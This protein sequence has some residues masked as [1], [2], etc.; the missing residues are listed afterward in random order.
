MRP[1]KE[2]KWRIL[3]IICT[4]V[5]SCFWALRQHFHTIGILAGRH[6][7]QSFEPPGEVVDRLKTKALRN[8]RKVESALA[9]HLAGGLDFHVAE[10]VHDSMAG[11][12][13]EQFLQLAAANHIVPADL[14]HGEGLV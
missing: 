5:R 6:T 1:W 14:G 8:L 11:L 4:I 3:H 13:V 10:V 2:M 12:L 7:G 9:N